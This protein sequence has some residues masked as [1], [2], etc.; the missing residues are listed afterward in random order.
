MWMKGKRLVKV[1]NNTQKRC[2]LIIKAQSMAERGF[3]YN[4]IERRLITISESQ[5]APPPTSQLLME[6]IESALKEANARPLLLPSDDLAFAHFM[7]DSHDGRILYS[8][9]ENQWFYWNEAY[10]QRISYS[11]VLKLCQET[12]EYIASITSGYDN[13]T[14]KQLKR[15]M[16]CQNHA[17]KKAMIQELQSIVLVSSAIFDTNS[18]L[19][20]FP[21]GTYDL[22]AGTFRAHR[23]KD[24]ITLCVGYDYNPIASY[25]PFVDFLVSSFKGQADIIMFISQLMGYLLFGGNPEQIVVYLVGHGK[26]GKTVFTRVLRA[27][28]GTYAGIIPAASLLASN[29]NDVKR[30]ELVRHRFARLIVALEFPE[31]RKL[32]ES[33]IKSISGEDENVGSLKYKDPV[34]YISQFTPIF[35]GNTL[36]TITG[37]DDGIW[38]RLIFLPWEVEISEEKRDR[39]LIKKLTTPEALSGIFN[40]ALAGYQRYT[41]CGTLIIPPQIEKIAKDY[42][43]NSCNIVPFIN[44]ECITSFATGYDVEVIKTP[45]SNLHSRYKIRCIRNM[46]PRLGIN[47][48]SRKLNQLGFLTDRGERG[49]RYKLGIIHKED[50]N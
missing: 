23:R 11:Q 14:E 12:A 6:I 13:L 47:E 43:R 29:R 7:N 1:A 40:F 38:R 21:N 31:K 22:I 15:V 35:S 4:E 32:N 18:Y 10:W 44:D 37:D 20:N 3:R 27:L 39:Q 34:E 49:I 46:E 45:I 33:A 48:F 17:R 2:D 25:N 50:F 26:N 16:S 5:D 8:D 9:V 42:R 41:Q 28:L 36:P 19:F 30:S 24:Y